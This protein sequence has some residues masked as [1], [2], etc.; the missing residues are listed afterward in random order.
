MPDIYTKNYCFVHV[1]PRLE[2]ANMKTRIT[3]TFAQP[4][5]TGNLK[6]NG[7]VYYFYDAI[8]REKNSFL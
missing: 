2:K 3:A 4:V 7:T 1:F 6:V 8:I 5:H